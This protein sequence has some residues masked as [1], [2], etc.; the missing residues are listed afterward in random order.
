MNAAKAQAWSGLSTCCSEWSDEM[1]ANEALLRDDAIRQFIVDGILTIP[2]G[3]AKEFHE[4]M[5]EAL[6]QSNREAANPRSNIIGAVPRLSAVTEAP[7]VRGA[8]VSLLGNK[9]RMHPYTVSHS[10]PLGTWGQLWHQDSAFDRPSEPWGLAL[11]IIRPPSPQ[12][13]AQL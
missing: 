13:W 5:V 4:D 1:C 8:L 2:S 3:L 10:N 7:A 11:S 9:V 6:E 12:R